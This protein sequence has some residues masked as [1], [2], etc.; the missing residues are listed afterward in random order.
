MSLITFTNKL[1]AVRFIMNRKVTRHELSSYHITANPAK[2]RLEIK[3]QDP[4][5]NRLRWKISFEEV[6]N[7]CPACS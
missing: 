1:N 2:R 5:G 3:M 4:K 6:E 7:A